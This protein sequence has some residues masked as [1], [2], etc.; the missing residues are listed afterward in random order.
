M[1]WLRWAMIV[2]ASIAGGVAILWVVG[3]YYHIR[4][5]VRRRHEP[6]TWKCQPKR[7]LRPDLARQAMM[8]S[9]ANLALG[10]LI[11][12]TLIYFILEGWEA[13]AIYFDVEDYGWAWTL[14]GVPLYFIIADALAYYAHRAMHNRFLFRHVH[15]WHHRYVATT[16]FV[17]TAM[18][19]VEFLVFQTVTLAP[20]FLIPFH[21]A[22]VI[23]TLV[24]VL[25]FNIID[26]SG[27]DLRSRWPWQ[28]PSRY[29]D[30]HHVYFHVNFGQHLMFWD[31]IHG[32]LRR[33]GRRYGK[34]VFGGKGA[35]DAAADDAGSEFVQY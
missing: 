4:Y 6:D 20:L 22:A 25:A 33:K 24:Y 14:A 17:V 2:A 1:D 28:G 15:R 31:R 26:H 21:F 19:P 7:F 16:P 29:H 35:P 12:G 30:D 9:T 11:T 23:V 3:G 32:T 34:D 27:V 18:H 13:P 5:Y 8:L 10:G